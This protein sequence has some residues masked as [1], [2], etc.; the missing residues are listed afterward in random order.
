MRLYLFRHGSLP[1]SCAG[2]FI[3]LQEVPLSDKG[4]SECL[5]LQKLAAKEQFDAVFAS[6]LRRTKESAELI[7]PGRDGIVFDDRLREMDFG[8]W[9]NLTFE[10]ITRLY[11]ESAA[12]WTQKSAD[13][14]FPGGG[15]AKG[16]K[17]AVKSFWD[18]LKAENFDSVAV[19]THGGVIVQFL[20]ILL[21]LEDDQ[22]WRLLPARGTLS[23]LEI[24]SV[25]GENRFTSRVLCLG[26][27]ERWQE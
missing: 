14:A 16:Q 27:G 12:F 17:Q 10:E 24:N 13:M 9:E 6:P 3:G 2:R 20:S 25:P 7:F 5:F 18:D 11:P 1:D 21:D 22:A 26:A 23:C 19:V 4:R 15:S 8:K